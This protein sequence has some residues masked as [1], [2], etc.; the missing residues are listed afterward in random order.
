MRGGARPAY[1]FLGGEPPPMQLSG[2]PMLP[3]KPGKAISEPESN[4]MATSKWETSRRIIFSVGVVLA[5]VL[6]L[7]ACVTT[8]GPAPGSYTVNMTT[9]PSDVSACTAV[10]DI[11]VPGGAPNK[12]IEFRNQAVGLGANTALVTV[13]IFGDA[14][15]VDGVAYRCPRS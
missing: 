2:N 9:D 6:I 1:C 10:G 4:A 3:V 15:P 14:T 8:T 12:D 5:L 13:T 11:K 7:D